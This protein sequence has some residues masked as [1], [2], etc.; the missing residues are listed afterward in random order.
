MLKCRYLSAEHDSHYDDAIRW[1]KAS[2]Y[3]LIK[4][5]RADEPKPETKTMAD[6]YQTKTDRLIALFV[7][8]P[9]EG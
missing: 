8:E 4:S 2:D 1:R 6:L 9:I 3:V 7:L 5:I